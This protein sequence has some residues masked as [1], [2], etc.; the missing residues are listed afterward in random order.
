MLLAVAAV[1]ARPT[2]AEAATS[3][4]ALH[5][6]PVFLG[7]AALVLALA[8]SAGAWCCALR[9]TGAEIR[10]REAWGC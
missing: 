10:F 4:Q 6:E 9:W 2:L 3:P 8:A 1:R 7:G 5:P